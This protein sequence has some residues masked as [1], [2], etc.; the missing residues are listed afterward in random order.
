MGGGGH[1]R[2]ASG[3]VAMCGVGQQAGLGFMQN[4]KVLN[5]NSGL[6]IIVILLCR[7]RFQK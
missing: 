4:W 1:A 2:R 7:Y 3:Q 6:D 5:K